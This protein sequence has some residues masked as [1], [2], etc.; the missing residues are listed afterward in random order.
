M[1]SARPQ[2]VSAA[3]VVNGDRLLLGRRA[4][5]PGRG[6]WVPPG[7]KV[8]PFES[9]AAAAVREVREETGLTIEVEGAP[10]AAGE[11]EIIDPDTDQHWVV[12]YSIAGLVDAG[13]VD[14]AYTL[15]PFTGDLDL[16]RFFTREELVLGLGMALRMFGH[17]ERI[18]RE[19]RWLP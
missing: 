1:T 13:V 12:I 10:G 16:A 4:R 14:A 5:D 2:L 3:L 11:A 6:M 18:L 9:L 15:G 19:N 17:N 7:G 8:L